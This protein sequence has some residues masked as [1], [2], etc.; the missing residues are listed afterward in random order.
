MMTLSQTTAPHRR[1][2]IGGQ[3]LLQERDEGR[4]DRLARDLV[5]EAAA[6]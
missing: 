1:S 4:A 6:C 5:E 3:E 2:R